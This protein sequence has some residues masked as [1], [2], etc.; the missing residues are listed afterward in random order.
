[1]VIY[2]NVSLKKYN[3]FGLNYYAQRMIRLN[4]EKEATELFN[5]TISWE[6]PLLIIG[7]GSNL[8]FTEDFR[9]TILFPDF[10]GKRIKAEEKDTGN[11]IVT[12][13]A[14]VIWDDFVEW[15]VKKGLGGVENLSLIPGTVSAAAVQNIGA[16]G[17]E[18]R[19]KIIEVKAISTNDGKIRSF[20]NHECEFGY[21]NSIFKNSGKGKYLISR[22]SFS[23]T[24]N[25]SLNL[26]Y[27][28]LS[29]EVARL[30]PATLENVRKGVINIRRSRLPDPEIS[31][32]AGSF[33]KNAV[34]RNS[35]AENLKKEYPEMPVY[36]DQ[37]GYTKLASGWLIDQC[38]WK[39]F[40]KGDAG[41]HEKQ[42]L[43]LI[44]YGN[45]TGLEIYKLSEDIKK[46][47]KDKFGVDLE[48]EVEIVGPI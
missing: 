6:K 40:R 41:V 39:G 28:S 43:V 1:M 7:S 30:G 32:N 21:R 48:R 29:E 25:P 45:A 3:T 23:L 15:T 2:K 44:N 11:I 26:S 13:G 18:A 22:V 33:F 31:G 34:V 19:E 36:P 27:G 16:Y 20:K 46:S 8:L 9:G 17:V 42:A 35:V 47:V 4:T 24:K 10:K 12:A 38:G 5:G 14:G 37:E